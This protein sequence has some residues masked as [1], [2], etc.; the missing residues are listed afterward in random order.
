MQRPPHPDIDHR[1]PDPRRVTSS[2]SPRQLAGLRALQVFG[3]SVA[4][5]T[6][7]GLAVVS[8]AG[9][10]TTS[11]IR[12]VQGQAPQYTVLIAGRDIIYC[13]YHQPCKDQGQREGLIQPPNTDTLMLV[14]VD[15]ASVQVLNIPRDTNVGEFNPR[16]G[17]AA[18]K[19]N[20]Q[21]WD[22]GPQA[23]M[24]AVETITGEHVDSYVV[25]RT[26]YVERVIDAL[27][28]LDVTVPEPGIEWVDNAAG[29]NLKLAPGDHH[30]DGRQG[31]LFLRVRKGFGDDYGRI[32]HQ[33]QAL[34]QL[35]GK[36]RTPQG[37][38]AL[39][40]I[41][42]GIGNGVE[43]NADPDLLLALRPYLARLKL[44]FS[45]LPT[46]PIPGTFNLAV[47]RERL[48]A[49]WGKPAA[50]SVPDVRVRIVDASG[51]GLG[52]GLVR[53]LQAM[54]YRDVELS[55][56]A[57]SREASQVFTQQEVA[58][59]GALADALNLPRLQGERFPVAAG[60]VGILLGTDAGTHLAALNDLS[61]T[62]ET[63]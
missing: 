55:A 9:G 12:A 3:L 20:S 25:V 49:V 17:I 37:L 53:A 40:T 5:L 7:G 4:A 44:A 33:K 14:K 2:P 15:G 62:P 36:L 42:G 29:V 45:T 63:P 22:G 51:D 61:P 48:A 32:D 50:I 56:V 39:P 30:L 28:G 31:V 60:E 16:L 18:Q 24:R 27:G 54:G 57:A 23:L 52:A 41:L 59:A 26:D 38:A 43:T 46:D 13:Y 47:N 11:V 58:Q 6:L 34:T 1:F 21:Y 8:T 35:A 10:Q 19:V